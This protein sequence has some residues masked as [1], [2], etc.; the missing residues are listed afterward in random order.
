MHIQCCI[1][2]WNSPRTLGFIATFCVY[3]SVVIGNPYNDLWSC[4]Y[5]TVNKHVQILTAHQSAGLILQQKDELKSKIN[6]ELNFLISYKTL[7]VKKLHLE[8][9][10]I[11]DPNLKKSRW[12]YDNWWAVN[13]QF[14]K[15]QNNSVKE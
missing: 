1:W 14:N 3:V 8:R 2:C 15:M 10:Y 9:K 12:E 13:G 7:W 5:E 11:A 6:D 4:N